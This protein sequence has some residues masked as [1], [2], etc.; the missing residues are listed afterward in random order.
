MQK[1]ILASSPE[2]QIRSF[3]DWYN[4]AEVKFELIKQ[5]YNREF[6]VLPPKHFNQKYGTRTL[7]LH[8]VQ[9]LD[10]I[11]WNQLK[12]KLT[13]KCLNLYYSL[14][15][16]KKGLPMLG[17]NLRERDTSDWKDNHYKHIIAY[18]LLI[19]IDAGS[20]DEITYAQ[21]SAL[22]I[23]DELDDCEVPFQLRF[24]GMGFHII[25]P[26]WF[27]R[28]VKIS[29]NPFAENNIYK[30]YTRILVNLHDRVSEM[31]DFKIADSRR[32]CK[33]PYSIAFYDGCEYVCAP[34][35]KRVELLDFNLENYKP[36]KWVCKMRGRSPLT[37]NS[38]FDNPE[39]FLK[40]WA[41]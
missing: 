40:R 37:F 16:Y 31:I 17:A 28:D 25:I 12:C 11:L 36:Q 23:V 22:K 7:R 24:S 32:I 39:K 10:F 14:A 3:I 19:D 34:I 35:N 30:L 38:E 5:T 20:H 6:A 2:H 9:H 18:D 21:E 15:T 27:F 8:S 26:Y 41:R 13:K 1:N 33:L 29:F 4:L